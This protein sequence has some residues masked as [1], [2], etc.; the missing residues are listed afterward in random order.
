MISISYTVNS[1]PVENIT[2]TTEVPTTLKPLNLSMPLLL[3]PNPL[4]GKSANS[5]VYARSF[6][7][8]SI[9]Q[10]RLEPKFLFV[11]LY[12]KVDN[13]PRVDFPSAG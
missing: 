1:I 4:D 6:P 2:T 8:N 11:V 12:F 13:V 5:P 9:E 7:R 10:H 3:L